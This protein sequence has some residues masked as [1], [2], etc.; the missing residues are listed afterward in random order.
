[1]RNLLIASALSGSLCLPIAAAQDNE[2]EEVVQAQILA[3]T[4]ILY[5]QFNEVE[6]VEY[7]DGTIEADG[8]V[9]FDLPVYPRRTYALIG[10]CDQDCSDLDLFVFADG[11]EV[12]SDT[13]VDDT[14]IVTFTAGSGEAL[15]AR[16]KMYD[17]D[18]IICYY[19]VG[20]YEIED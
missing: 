6:P 14:P 13:E 19:G 2:Y 18:S 1:M 20:L 8:S 12:D 10:A 5:E 15:S 9:S 17:C 3:A 11:S 16:V 4:L 7:F